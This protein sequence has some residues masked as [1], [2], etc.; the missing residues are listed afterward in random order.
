[1]STFDLINMME[2]FFLFVPVFCESKQLCL[3]FSPKCRGSRC[4]SAQ[5]RST[6]VILPLLQCPTWFWVPATSRPWR[7]PRSL[8]FPRTL[9]LDVRSESFLFPLDSPR[10]VVNRKL[11][12][13]RKLLQLSLFLPTVPPPWAP[14]NSAWPLRPQASACGGGRGPVKWMWHKL[15]GR[16]LPATYHTLLLENSLFLHFLLQLSL[17]PFNPRR[18]LPLT[19]VYS[20]MLMTWKCS[21][22]SGGN[23]CMYLE[24]RDTKSQ[25]IRQP[26]CF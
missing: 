12:Q 2:V 15:S 18:L 10:P 8:P 14:C 25:C 22:C 20:S 5:N 23:S 16:H 11:S 7:T 13:R 9:S 3:C 17:S 24:N 21:K 26:K 6:D 19:V 1:M 4:F